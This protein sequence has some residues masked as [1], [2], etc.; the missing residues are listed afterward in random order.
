M[1]LS[2]PAN[3]RITWELVRNADLGPCHR[4]I[5]SET[6]AWDLAFCVLTSPPGDS[7][8]CSL[9]NHWGKCYTVRSRKVP[10]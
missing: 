7:D 1:V 3:I 4:H 5:E 9:E 8:V 6:L 2:P 10:S